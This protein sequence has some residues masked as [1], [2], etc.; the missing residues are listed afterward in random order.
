MCSVETTLE[1][2]EEELVSYSQFIDSETLKEVL[3]D[4]AKD[5]RV[6]EKIKNAQMEAQNINLDSHDSQDSVIL[7]E[8]EVDS[9]L[10]PPPSKVAV[11]RPTAA[12][13]GITDTV[14]SKPTDAN[15]GIVVVNL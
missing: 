11:M 14:E 8:N 5:P 6:L 3:G 1:D 9:E 13:L 12:S 4:K 15:D 7:Q 10:M 2:L